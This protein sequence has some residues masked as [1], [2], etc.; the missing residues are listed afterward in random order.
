MLVISVIL[1]IVFIFKPKQHL[2]RGRNTCSSLNPLKSRV[3]PSARGTNRAANAALIAGGG[4]EAL[5]PGVRTE[6]RLSAVHTA[7]RRYN[8]VIGCLPET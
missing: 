7:E 2:K 3:H 4:I 6:E 1:Y 8:S 5:E